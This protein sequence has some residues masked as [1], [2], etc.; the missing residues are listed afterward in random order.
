MSS[1]RP[2]KGTVRVPSDKSISHRVALFSAVAEGTSQVSGLL[3]SLDVRSTL[4]AIEA[5]G[6]HHELV[7]D[8]TG[9][10]GTITGWGDRG[11]ALS[12]DAANVAATAATA[13]TVAIDCGN[14]GTTTRLLMGILAGYPLS[15]LLQGDRS[16]SARPMKRIAAPLTQMGARIEAPSTHGNPSATPSATPADTLPLVV[17][18]S[19]SLTAID[20][21]SPVASAQVKSAVLL[22]GLHAQGTTSVTEPHKSRDHTE[23]LLPAYGAE[24]AVDGLT[25][26]ILGGQKLHAFDV[27]VPGDPSSAAFLLAAAALIPGSVVT[28]REVLL[29]PTRIGFLNVM[30]RMG[31][32]IAITTSNIKRLGAE[33]VGA[34]TV[35]YRP[36]LAATTIEAH[37]IPALIDE[38]PILALL[39]TA[40]VGTTA[41]EQVGELRVKESDR[42]AAII[43]GLRALG[44]SASAHGDDLH[45]SLGYPQ[46]PT[47][48]TPLE[49]HGDHRLAMTWAIAA[50]AFAPQLEIV[51]KECVSVSYPTFYSDL[52][53]LSL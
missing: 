45:V 21:V 24:V 19:A 10:S 30:K 11:P 8:E 5:L 22:A 17:R 48:T 35:R 2:L 38:V 40:A 20:Y 18:G 29:N 31:A 4:D 51:D 47:T 37:E 33:K 16:L 43:T 46:A 13:A 42:L 27:A 34:I 15:V 49:T 39:A 44:C 14:S 12:P 53:R 6:A 52:E 23:L 41:F 50:R 25:A 26:S 9:L 36:G 1:V 28:A 3:D 32:D 7:A